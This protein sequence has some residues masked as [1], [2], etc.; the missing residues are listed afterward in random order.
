MF[1]A[2]L[3]PGLALFTDAAPHYA[4][5]DGP[6]QRGVK[7]TGGSQGSTGTRQEGGQTESGPGRPPPAQPEKME[8]GTE[9][10][11]QNSR[12]LNTDVDGDETGRQREGPNLPV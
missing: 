4:L 6:V 3:R 12:M 2:A 7:Q 1:L 10:R 8:E 11:H 9:E 5:W